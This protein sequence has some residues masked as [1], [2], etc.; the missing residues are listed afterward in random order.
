VDNVSV[1][2]GLKDLLLLGSLDRVGR[3]EDKV[4]FLEL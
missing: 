1:G 4:K 3:R 2:I